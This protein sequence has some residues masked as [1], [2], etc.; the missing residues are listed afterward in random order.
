MERTEMYAGPHVPEAPNLLVETNRS[1]HTT[2]ETGSDEIASKQLDGFINGWRDI[3][4]I[5]VATGNRVDP[6]GTCSGAEREDLA[7]IVLAL[8]SV[9][10]LK[11]MDGRPLETC[12]V[13]AGRQSTVLR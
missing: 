13:T 7:P 11:E 3:V 1:Y 9:P 5:F 2:F 12:S 6:V 4:S 10:T 8:L